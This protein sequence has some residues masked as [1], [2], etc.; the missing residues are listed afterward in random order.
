MQ[1]MPRKLSPEGKR[2]WLIDRMNEL[3]E[4]KRSIRTHIREMSNNF[5]GKKDR[6]F[7]AWLHRAKSKIS[8]LILIL[9][10][11]CVR[12]IVEQI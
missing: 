12:L 4:T 5:Q 6:E 2:L 8:H 10:I 9:L 1:C 3:D 11:K 7:F